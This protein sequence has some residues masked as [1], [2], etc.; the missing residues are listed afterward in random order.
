MRTNIDAGVALLERFRK[1][2]GVKGVFKT[3]AKQL[4][5]QV[6]EW[7]WLEL[8]EERREERVEM[9]AKGRIDLWVDVPPGW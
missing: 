2:G 1:C 4:R 7:R 6:E 5:A 3:A 8:M 9:L